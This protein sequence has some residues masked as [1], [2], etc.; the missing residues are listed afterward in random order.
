[1]RARGGRR[2]LW[3]DYPQTLEAHTRAAQN[4]TMVLDTARADLLEGLAC[5]LR[6]LLAIE[7]ALDEAE[8]ERAA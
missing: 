7:R 4:D 3:A 1:M 6:G 8:R 2:L 5:E